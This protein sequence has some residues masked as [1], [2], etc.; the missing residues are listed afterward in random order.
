MLSNSLAS[1][2]ATLRTWRTRTDIFLAICLDRF[3][4]TP[5]L[6]RPK[7]L[8]KMSELPNCIYY[9]L[10]IFNKHLLHIIHLHTG[11]ISIPR[12]SNFDTQPMCKIY[13]WN[14]SAR[15]R[16]NV[17]IGGAGTRTRR[18][19]VSCGEIQDSRKETSWR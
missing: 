17:E 1:W 19:A 6:R 9:D 15:S 5:C 11:K 2:I 8:H 3:R 13:N 10:L 18:L 16:H 14:H 7:H 4:T 12:H